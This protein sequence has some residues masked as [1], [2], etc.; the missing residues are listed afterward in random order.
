MIELITAYV[1][2]PMDQLCPFKLKLELTVIGDFPTSVVICLRKVM[3]DAITMVPNNTPVAYVKNT[4][5]APV[6]LTRLL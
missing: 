5:A 4:L 6:N 1:H 2:T 3:L